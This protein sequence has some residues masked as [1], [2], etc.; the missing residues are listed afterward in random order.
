MPQVGQLQVVSLQGGSG[1][2]L[3]E[4]QLE[5]RVSA[6]GPTCVLTV[7]DLQA[8]MLGLAGFLLLPPCP[9]LLAQWLRSIIRQLHK[10]R[11][12]SCIM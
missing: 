9:P 3:R 12:S 11:G 4:R 2:Y 5:I 10:R 7:A 1:G 8:R 6:E